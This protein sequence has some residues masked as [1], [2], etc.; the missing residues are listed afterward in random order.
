MPYVMQ[1]QYQYDSVLSSILNK[2]APLRKRVIAIRPSAPW[3]IEEIKEQK[4]ICRRLKRRWR[5][6]RLTSEYQSYTEQRTVV[7]N[8]IFKTG[9][10]F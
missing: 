10:L 7:K 9:L 4:E 2:H 5:R 8:T 1:Y 6:S 3:Y